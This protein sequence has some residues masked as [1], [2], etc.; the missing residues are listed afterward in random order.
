M[1]RSAFHTGM[2]TKRRLLLPFTIQLYLH[3]SG[4]AWV[5][6]VRFNARERDAGIAVLKASLAPDPKNLFSRVFK[7]AVI[8]APIGT[9][10]NAP[11]D[12]TT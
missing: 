12:R 8:E 2:L 6:D 9:I 3:G 4:L 1:I 7:G 11:V 10:Y 5:A